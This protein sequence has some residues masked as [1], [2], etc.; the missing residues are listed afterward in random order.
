MS[1][2]EHTAYEDMSD[3]Q[4]SKQ[5]GLHVK[6][7]QA[8]KVVHPH[9]KKSH[10]K[11]TNNPLR[12]KPLNIQH[13]CIGQQRKEV[14]KALLHFTKLVHKSERRG[15]NSCADCSYFRRHINFMLQEAESVQRLRRRREKFNAPITL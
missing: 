5:I 4:S 11:Q 10:G 3:Q 9:C 7:E 12:V 15:R 2:S 13:H 1:I 8:C 6:C 14:N